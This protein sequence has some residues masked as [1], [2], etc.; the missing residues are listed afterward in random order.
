MPCFLW[1][2]AGSP[3]IEW[4]SS[5]PRLRGALSAIT[6]AVVGVILNLFLWFA[7]NVMFSKTDSLSLGIGRFLIP[8]ITSLDWRVIILAAGSALILLMLRLP[9][10]YVLIFSAIGGVLFS[11]FW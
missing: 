9:I 11:L 1:I 5:Q 6:A 8:D 3:Y 10:I 2:F 7:I 4:I